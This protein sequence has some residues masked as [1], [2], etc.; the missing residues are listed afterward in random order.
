MNSLQLFILLQNQIMVIKHRME[1]TRM[2]PQ[3]RKRF[4]QLV[5]LPNKASHLQ[6]LAA[7]GTVYKQN[8]LEAK[9]WDDVKRNGGEGL[10]QPKDI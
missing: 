2:A 9:F 4:K 10:L 8:N 6:V 1:L 7:I 5:G 3:A